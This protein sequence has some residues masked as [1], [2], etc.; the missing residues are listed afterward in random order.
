MS[1]TIICA[2]ISAGVAIVSQ[3]LVNQNAR[4][5]DS[6]DRAVRQTKLDDRLGSIEKKLDEHNGYAQKFEEVSIRMVKIEKDIEYIK[7]K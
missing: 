4:K 1:D 3:L 7:D 2:L 6:I 5:K